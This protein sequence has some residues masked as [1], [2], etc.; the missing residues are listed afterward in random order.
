MQQTLDVRKA[1]VGDEVVLKTTQAI[2]QNGH[3]VVNKGARLVGHVTD[4]Q[5]RA[6]GNTESRISLLFDRLESGSLST[7]ISATITS[8]TQAA[9]HT[10]V[11]NDDLISDTSA[12]T[13]TTA[14]GGASSSGGG[15]LGG[16]GSTAGG[17]VGGVTST[18]GNVVNTTTQATGEVVSSTTGAVGGTTRGV[19]QTVR[20]L[21]ISQSAGASAEGGSTLS[22]TGGNLRLEKN[23][24]FMLTLNESANVGREHEQ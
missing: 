2:K 16:V 8:V 7:P 14:G 21:R 6:Q 11:A 17:V 23:T 5:Q 1:H 4:V 15:L 13:T 18:A 3:T 9:A 19:G 20:G 24:T 10:S 12:G 22:L